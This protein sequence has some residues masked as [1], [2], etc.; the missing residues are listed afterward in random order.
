M[1]QEKE[2]KKE[3]D[4]NVKRIKSGKKICYKKY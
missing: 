1:N 3:M 2:N 4:S